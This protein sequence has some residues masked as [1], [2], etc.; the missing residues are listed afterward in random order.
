MQFLLISLLNSHLSVFRQQLSD[1]IFGRVHLLSEALLFDSFLVINLAQLLQA[2]LTFVE[3]KA[4]SLVVVPKILDLSLPVFNLI[5]AIFK[6]FTR[7]FILSMQVVEL[8]QLIFDFALQI[9]DVN[10]EVVSL[11]LELLADHLLLIQL[12]IQLVNFALQFIF[13]TALFR[14]RLCLEIGVIQVQLLLFTLNHL[15]LQTNLLQRRRCLLH[16]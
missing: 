10:E 15:E 13:N 14:S 5:F 9:H 16:F 4:Q 3:S 8:E 11:F 2:A 1:T 12:T 7:I 6:L